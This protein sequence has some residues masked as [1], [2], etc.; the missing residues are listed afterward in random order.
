MQSKGLYFARV[1]YLFIYFLP[2]E[3][4]DGEW[5]ERRLLVGALELL[6]KNRQKFP[7]P[8]L[9]FTWGKKSKNFDPNFDT[10]PVWSFAILN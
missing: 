3:P 1:L 9:F 7:T 10:T 4:I 8:P 6:H 5:P 2:P